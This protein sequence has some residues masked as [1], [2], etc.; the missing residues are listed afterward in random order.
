M[1]RRKIVKVLILIFFLLVILFSYNKFFKKQNLEQEPITET[2]ENYSSN[3]LKDV[4]YT[5]KDIKGNEYELSQH[6]W[7]LGFYKY[8]QKL[9]DAKKGII[10]KTGETLKKK[11][12]KP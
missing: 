8:K 6:N 12:G 3:V 4:N 2:P 11:Q 5:T 7:K 10:K 9:N 1:E